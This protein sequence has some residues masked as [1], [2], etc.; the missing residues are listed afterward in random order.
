MKP[1]LARDLL[2]DSYIPLP[3]HPSSFLFAFSSNFLTTRPG[4]SQNHVGVNDQHDQ[5]GLCA[6]AKATKRWRRRPGCHGQLNIWCRSQGRRYGKRR[7]V[8]P[9]TSSASLSIDRTLEH[10]RS[11]QNVLGTTLHH[12]H[13]QQHQNRCHCRRLISCQENHRERRASST[14]AMGH[15]WSRTFSES[16]EFL[17]LLDCIH[18]WGSPRWRLAY[19]ALPASQNNRR[20]QCTTGAPMPPS[21][22]TTLRTPHPLRTF[23]SGSKVCV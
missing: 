8:S 11:R 2:L 7:F 10:F 4:I 15:S 5:H 20:L 9:S 13:L 21:S 12:K 23:V 17:I 22:S 6:G 14:A 3:S 1:Y 16:R 18:D 19:P